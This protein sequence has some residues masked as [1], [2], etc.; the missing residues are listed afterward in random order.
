[1]STRNT[2]THTCAYTVHAPALQKYNIA[3][4]PFNDLTVA[5]CCVPCAIC[6][7]GGCW[8][9]VVAGCVCMMQRHITCM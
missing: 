6:E 2:R 9:M 8:T 7:S 1:L 5:M 4:N 3:G